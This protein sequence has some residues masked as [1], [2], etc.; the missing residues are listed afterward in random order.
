MIQLS[1]FL[2]PRPE[3]SWKLIR[4]VGVDNVVGVLNGAEQD[5]RMFASVGAGGWKAD[6]RDEVPWSE[7]ALAHNIETY[8]DHGFTLVA[9]EDTA[10]IDKARLG[11]RRP[12]RADR[13]RHHAGPR[14]GAPRHPDPRL[15]LDGAVELGPHRHRDRRPRRRPR[16]RLRP[17]HRAGEGAARRSRARSRA[18]RCGQGWSTSST[19]SCP[20][21][22]R[23]GVRLAMHPDD[24]P[25]PV[26]RNLPRIMSSVESFRR[27]LSL[28]PSDYNGI[29]FCQGN[30]ALMPEVIDGTDID[31]RPHPR[32]RHREDPV[33]PLP[34]CQGH[35]RLVPGD[36]PRRRPDRHAGVHGG[37]LRDRL[38]GR[39]ASRPRADARGRDQQPTRLRDA[40]PPLRDRL[41]PRV[42]SSRRT[43]IPRPRH[44][45][46]RAHRPAQWRSPLRARRGDRP[47]RADGT[48]STA[49]TCVTAEPLSGG[50]SSDIWLIRTE[51]GRD[52]AE[53]SA[54]AAQ[55]RGR[56]DGA[57]RPGRV[58]GGVARLR[59]GGCSRRVPARARLRRGVVRDRP[60]VPRPGAVPQLEDRAPRR[61][62]RRRLRR[63]RRP[64]PRT[65]PQRVGPRA[66]PGATVRSSGSLRVVAHRAVPRCAPHAAVP[67]AH[68]RAA[69]VIE[70]LRATRIALVHGD[71]S[72][73]NILVGDPPG[74]P[75]RRVRDLVGSRVRRR[76]LPHPPDA[77]A[78]AP[79]RARPR[80]CRSRPQAI[81]RRLP[82]PRWTGSRDADAA[83][84]IERIC[85]G[86]DA[87]P[88][89]RRLA[90]RVPGRADARRRAQ[91][92][93]VE[94][95]LTGRPVD[96]VIET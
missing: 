87:G 43:G 52:G 29:T 50:V 25:Q 22:R 95:L 6:D 80:L 2:P 88:R 53:A 45:R 11:P 82:R 51:R 47:A 14:D 31:P 84:R 92:L 75:R 17:R 24:P 37:V 21:P 1:E 55:G 77:Q 32:V 9:L 23:P 19:P 81:H 46:P 41:H 15:Q 90:R 74:V 39:D 60:G 68:A 13:Q 30:F 33:R 18:S 26:D 96:D 10:P 27:L 91:D 58:G 36:V 66:A 49:A 93:A 86:A 65:H 12:R 59:V 7:A 83:A 67:E 38:R 78:A 42:S 48:S 94:A 3:E 16:H 20:S 71:V 54:A 44:E 85:A 34:R 8:D 70:S 63:E 79:A 61:S 72:P 69:A 73:K 76:V 57:A 89:G 64:R 56:L 62:D 4:Q 28:H 5:Q 40:R 35:R